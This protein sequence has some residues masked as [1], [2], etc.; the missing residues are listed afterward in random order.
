[1]LLASEVAARA[2]NVVVLF[3]HKRGSTNG[4]DRLEETFRNGYASYWVEDVALAA[5]ARAAGVEP[6]TNELARCRQ[7][8]FANFR[9]K[10]DR[11]YDDILKLEGLDRRY[12]DD[13]VRAEALRATMESYWAEQE[14][15]NLP[16]DYADEQIRKMEQWNLKMAETN[17]LQFAKATNVWEKIKKGMDFAAAAK[18]FSEIEEERVDAGEWAVVDAKFLSDEPALLAWLKAAKPGDVSPPIAADNGIVI[19][20]LDGVEP[21]DGFAVSR[22]FF[23]LGRTLVPASKEEIVAAAKEEWA[24]GLFKRKLAELVAAANADLKEENKDKEQVK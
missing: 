18:T 3:G 24:K 10:G 22:I 16:S 20:R 15:A 19:A 21:D 2:H 9:T 11:S 8:A 14:P 6:G 13:Q 7:Q 1:M 5:A 17:R 4:L 23:R 12:W